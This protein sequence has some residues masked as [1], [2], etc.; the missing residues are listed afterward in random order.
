MIVFYIF[1]LPVVPD[2]REG[3]PVGSPSDAVFFLL[4]LSTDIPCERSVAAD[5]GARLVADDDPA[6][7][8]R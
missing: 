3:R 2:R 6:V 7:V 4:S 5:P 8:C 1:H